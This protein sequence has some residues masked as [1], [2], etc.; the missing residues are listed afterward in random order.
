M[1]NKI[2]SILQSRKAPPKEVEQAYNS[3]Y[4]NANKCVCCHLVIPEGIQYCPF[5]G[6]VPKRKESEV[7]TE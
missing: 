7:D 6:D 5:C 4:D 1:L 3:V 2:G